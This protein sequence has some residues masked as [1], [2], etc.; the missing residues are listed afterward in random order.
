ML[1]KTIA[2]I[3]SMTLLLG[4]MTTT[5]TAAVIGTQQA[6]DG[7][8]SQQQIARVTQALDRQ[9]VQQAMIRMGV[10]PEQAKLR[11]SSLSPQ[12]LAQLDQ[13]LDSLPAG[14][15]VLALIGAVFVVLLILEFTGVINVFKGV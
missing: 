5:A 3:V 7:P 2:L 6:I 9:E 14:G 12:E 11:V 15:S 10:D 1:K 4:G 8:S 13:Q